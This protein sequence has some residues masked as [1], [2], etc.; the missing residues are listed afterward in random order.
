[1]YKDIPLSNASSILLNFSISQKNLSSLTWR[2]S[3]I[4]NEVCVPNNTGKKDWAQDS[5]VFNEEGL[6]WHTATVPTS[7]SIKK[8]ARSRSASPAEPSV[9]IE[10][11][12]PET[13]ANPWEVLYSAKQ[14]F[15]NVN[16]SGGI[17]EAGSRSSLRPKLWWRS[18]P[19]IL[20]LKA[21]P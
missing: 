7:S 15:G 4:V 1:M 17:Q 12:F 16:P 14:G 3:D 5:T 21:M 8:E 2:N 13:W 19:I 10:P 20:Y 18:I 6:G 11:M 9:Y